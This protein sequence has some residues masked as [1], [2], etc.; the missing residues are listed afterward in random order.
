MNLM[1][2]PSNASLILSVAPFSP[3]GTAGFPGMVLFCLRS[4]N[5]VEMQWNGLQWN[6]MDCNEQQR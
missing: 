5:R 1:F 4:S 6:G 2:P 3:T